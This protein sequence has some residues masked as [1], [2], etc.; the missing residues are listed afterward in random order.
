LKRIA[1]RG[2]LDEENA[3]RTVL[4]I[5]AA[6]GRPLDL[7]I[8]SPGGVF[9]AAIAILLE[10]EEHD[11][12]VATTVTGEAC[13]AAA[14]VALGGDVRRIDR[15]STM[16]LHYPTPP[17]RNAAAAVRAAVGEYTGRPEKEIRAWLAREKHFTAA[18]AVQ[19]GLAD[20]VIAADAPELVQARDPPRRR[21]QWLRAWR[22][23]FE[24]FDLRL[25][26]TGESLVA[27][28]RRAVSLR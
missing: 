3:S 1:I 20:R 6:A 11:R 25:D 22:E 12:W 19:L 8:S 16:M 27:R 17:S 18:E 2:F 28:R 13:S 7:R 5:R 9:A 23:T 21:A 4:A 26:Q 14:I 10:T 15:C 24:E